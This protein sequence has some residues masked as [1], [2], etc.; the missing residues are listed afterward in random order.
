[1]VTEYKLRLALETWEKCLELC[2]PDAMPSSLLAPHKCHPLIFN[3]TAMFR[4]AWARLEVDL[5]MVQEALRYHDSYEVGAAMSNA[6]NKVKRSS[7][8][9]KVIQD[10]YNCIETA[11]VQGVRWVARTSPTS[12]SIEHPLCGMDLM[13]ILTLWLYRLEHDEEPATE[14]E[15]SMYNKVRQPL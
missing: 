11:V 3:A 1:M 7:A 14:E 13:I 10:C 2:E 8:M 15:L 9:L 5:K 6:R 4:N 12:W